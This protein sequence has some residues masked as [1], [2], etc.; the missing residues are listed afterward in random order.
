MITKACDSP[1]ASCRRSGGVLLPVWARRNGGEYPENWRKSGNDETAANNDVRTKGDLR[2]STENLAT[3]KQ[4]SEEAQ[5]CRN[6]I[7]S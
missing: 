5:T 3:L 4:R 7:D 1:L 2:V 6:S